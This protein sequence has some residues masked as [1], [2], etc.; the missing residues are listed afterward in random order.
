MHNRSIEFAKKFSVPVHVRSSFSDVRGSMIVAEPESAD[1]AVCGAAVIKDEARISLLGVPDR[2]GVSLEVFSRIAARNVTVD[3]IVQN[4]GEGGTADIS[5]TVPKKE[6]AITLEAVREAA[7][8]LGAM[9]VTWDDNVAKVSVVGLGMARQTGVA[10]KMFAALAA[11][12]INIQMISTSEIKI[13]AVIDRSQAAE[14]LR[15]VHKAFELE[16]EP[17]GRVAAAT[18]RMTAVDAADVVRRLESEDME[19]LLIDDISLDDT[20]ARVTIA[21]VPDRPGLAAQIFRRVAAAGIVVDIIVQGHDRHAGCPSLT[22]SVPRNKLGEVVAVAQQL[23]QEFSCKAVSSA[24]KIAKLSVSG[25]G[26]RSHIVA[27]FRALAAAGINV[28]MMNTSEVRVNVV[29]DGGEGQQGLQTLK[30]AFADAMR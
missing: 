10:E 27:V 25:V 9:D 18:P 5:F 15:A 24:P 13:S 16:R 7:Q 4:V 14:G 3:M 8:S 6:L 17:A 2:P 23:A 12:G 20:Q 19:K 28:A 30:A 29:V 22:F 11:A 1:V 26:L 21:G